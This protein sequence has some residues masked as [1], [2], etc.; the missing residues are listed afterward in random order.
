MLDGVYSQPQ[1]RL[2]DLGL[3]FGSV[4]GD[5]EVGSENWQKRNCW[6]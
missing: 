6:L 1:K 4:W 5:F 3:T 2:K